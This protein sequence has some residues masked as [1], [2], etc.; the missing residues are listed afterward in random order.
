MRFLVP[1]PTSTYGSKLRR[2]FSVI[3]LMIC[4]ILI[5]QIYLGSSVG[6]TPQAQFGL[7]LVQIGWAFLYFIAVVAT[8]PFLTSKKFWPDPVRLAFDGLIS[9]LQTIL[10]FAL[11]YEV[12]GL[13]PPNAGETGIKRDFV[14]FSA[15][16]FS[17]LGFGDFQPKPDARLYAAA[18]SILGNLHLGIIVGVT[19]FAAQQPPS[20][21][22]QNQ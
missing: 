16:T 10:A 19:F 22:D 5:L 3:S 8:I 6:N 12:L 7:S 21:D 17:T 1:K 2:V 15:V 9:I 18:Q 20:D 14:Y 13:V 11:I 4:L